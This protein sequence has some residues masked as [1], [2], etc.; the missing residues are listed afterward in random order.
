MV[1]QDCVPCTLKPFIKLARSQTMSKA[2]PKIAEPESAD[3]HVEI[4]WVPTEEEDKMLTIT[5]EQV[6]NY[7]AADSSSPPFRNCCQWPQLQQYA[8]RQCLAVFITS[9]SV[10]ISICRSTKAQGRGRSSTPPGRRLDGVCLPPLCGHACRMHLG[11]TPAI[12]TPQPWL[13]L[14][15]CHCQ[16]LLPL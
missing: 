1:L 10:A 4:G 12:T 15:C 7:S 8:V 3:A 11:G 5:S 16:P 2:S 14:V 13:E 9:S 6:S